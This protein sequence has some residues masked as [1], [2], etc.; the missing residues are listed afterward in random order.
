MVKFINILIVCFFLF[1]CRKDKVQA[2]PQYM[3]T[4]LSFLN[5]EWKFVKGAFGGDQYNFPREFYYQ[6]DIN[7]VIKFVQNEILSIN[8]QNSSTSYKLNLTGITEAEDFK[9]ISFRNQAHELIRFSFTPSLNK[10]ECEQSFFLITPPICF[11]QGTLRY[12]QYEKI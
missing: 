8:Y 1:G 3:N 2:P 10:L 11:E 4:D 9:I 12:S 5:G 6:N 7:C